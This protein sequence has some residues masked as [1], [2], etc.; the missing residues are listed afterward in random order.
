MIFIAFF[1]FLITSIF[2]IIVIFVLGLLMLHVLI[3][4]IYYLDKAK[5]NQNDEYDRHKNVRDIGCICP[6]KCEDS[7]NCTGEWCCIDIRCCIHGRRKSEFV[8]I[9]EKLREEIC[10]KCREWSKS[11][12][13]EYNLT[14]KLNLQ[15]WECSNKSCDLTVER[16]NAL[17][18][19]AYENGYTTFETIYDYVCQVL[20]D[21]DCHYVLK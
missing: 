11:S 15:S 17:I 13:N 18:L 21:E 7:R 10:P 20:S 14:S 6:K 9:A 1:L 12:R 5:P 8:K 16:Y 19:E 3:I 2:R 4:V